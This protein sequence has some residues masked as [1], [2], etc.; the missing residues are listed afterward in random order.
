[1]PEKIA[2]QC[3]VPKDRPTND[4]ARWRL[5]NTEKA[6]G[7]RTNAKKIS[8]PSQMIKDKNMR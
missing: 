6:V 1:M 7:A 8:P 4:P 2:I 3:S 5:G